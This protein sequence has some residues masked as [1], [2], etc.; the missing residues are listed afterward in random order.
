MLQPLIQTPLLAVV[1]TLAFWW[2]A[3]PR[4]RSSIQLQ[5][6]DHR[7]LSRTASLGFLVLLLA[8][9]LLLV[10][11]APGATLAAIA[12]MTITLPAF[13]IVTE[14]DREGFWRK[15]RNQL[16]GGAGAALVS[17]SLTL[18]LVE[19]AFAPALMALAIAR[20]CHRKELHLYWENAQDL[21]AVQ[22][23]LLQ[24]DAKIHCLKI[25]QPEMPSV[26]PSPLPRLE[27]LPQRKIV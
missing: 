5:K 10:S 15:R 8:Q 11:S 25:T 23:K 12:L 16:L 3:T 21:K 27:V 18:F 26:T 4:K 22:E 6:E 9:G 13:S 20:Q 7:W 17:I 14:S 1:L 19:P 2:W 24:L